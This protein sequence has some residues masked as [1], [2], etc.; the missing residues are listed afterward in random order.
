MGSIHFDQLPQKSFISEYR[1]SAEPMAFNQWIWGVYE[2]LCFLISGIIVAIHD[3]NPYYRI[4][5]AYIQKL[6]SVC[7]VTSVYMIGLRD[8]YQGLTIYF[9]DIEFSLNQ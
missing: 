3:G 8:H 2:Y 5:R 4:K 6:P 9:H 7:I 1:K